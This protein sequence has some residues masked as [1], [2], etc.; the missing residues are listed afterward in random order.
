MPRSRQLTAK[1]AHFKTVTKHPTRDLSTPF[2][3]LMTIY[4][5]V[6]IKPQQNVTTPGQI[7]NHILAAKEITAKSSE[8]SICIQ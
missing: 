2:Q 1:I 8:I 6:K 7:L 5:I 4:G 3:H